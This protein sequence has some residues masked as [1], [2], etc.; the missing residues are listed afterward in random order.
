MTSKTEGKAYADNKGV[1]LLVKYDHRLREQVCLHTPG[2]IVW[3]QDTRTC[4][5]VHC[6]GGS[7]QTCSYVMYARLPGLLCC[8]GEVPCRAVL[9]QHVKGCGMCIRHCPAPPPRLLV[10]AWRTW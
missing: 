2:N 4:N 8:G 7:G 9:H 10:L 1:P 5:C 3:L 6:G